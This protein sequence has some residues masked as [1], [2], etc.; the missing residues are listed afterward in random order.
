ME[1]SI[2]EAGMLL[3]F[4]ASWPFAVYRTWK[5]KSCHAKSFVF[6]WMVFVGYIFGIMHKLM[7]SLDWVIYLYLFNGFL[8]GLDLILSY[9][10]R[11]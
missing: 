8:V 4:G 3:C 7:V 11:K 6:M 9:R 1:V 5:T 2:F 10:Y